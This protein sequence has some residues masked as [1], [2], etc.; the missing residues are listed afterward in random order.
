MKNVLMI[1]VFMLIAGG[2][3]AQSNKEDIDLIQAALGK[4]KKAI[5]NEFM[6]VEGAQKDAFW[7]IYDEYEVKRK[8]LGKRRINLLEKYVNGYETMTDMD[9]EQSLKDIMKLSDD[10][11][12][13][14]VTYTNKMKKPAGI[15]AAAQFYQL[16]NYLLSVVRAQ[17]LGNIPVLGGKR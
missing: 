1:L 11:N 2:S 7:S 4:D 6:I 13:L 9:T 10:T 8:E 16:E 14:I 15:K 5:F 3:I 17:L 12:T